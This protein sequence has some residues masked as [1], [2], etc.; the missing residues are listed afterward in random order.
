MALKMLAEAHSHL[1][2]LR[3][4]QVQVSIHYILFEA[5]YARA[6]RSNP[7]LFGTPFALADF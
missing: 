5:A 4:V 7:I 6:I 2:A 3:V 1:L